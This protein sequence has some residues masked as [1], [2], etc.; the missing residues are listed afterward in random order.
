MYMHMYVYMYV[1]VYVY[2]CFIPLRHVT[3]T[4]CPHLLLDF[5]APVQPSAEKS[6]CRR[7]KRANRLKSSTV[8]STKLEYTMGLGDSHIPTSWLLLYMCFSC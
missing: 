6:T 3:G 2:V 8:D 5:H 4:S 7:A 1:Y